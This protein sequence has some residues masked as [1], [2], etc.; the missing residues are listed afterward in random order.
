MSLED[1]SQLIGIIGLLFCATSG[2]W[3]TTKQILLSL[4]FGLL[5]FITHYLL[6]GA[7]AGAA[8]D[9]VALARSLSAIRWPHRHKVRNLFYGMPFIIFA[10]Q[11]YTLSNA[12][13]CLAAL[14]NTKASFHRSPQAMRFYNIC[15]APFWVFYNVS[16]YSYAG[17]AGDALGLCLNI[18]G[19]YLYTKRKPR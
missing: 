6:L 17:M 18:F 11:A 12:F 19:L 10:L 8:V 5:M 2:L 4:S 16:N 1:I 13:V 9:S 7:Y 15:A 3:P 14:V